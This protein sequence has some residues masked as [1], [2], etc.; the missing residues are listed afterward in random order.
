MLDALL[1]FS[2]HH[3]WLV[4]AVAG[5]VL[6]AG[7]GSLNLL[8]IDVFPDLDRPRVVVMVEAGGM[9]PE[10]IETRITV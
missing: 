1:R 2:L 4:M 8:P 6:L 3:R 5:L 9:A 10:E 7:Y